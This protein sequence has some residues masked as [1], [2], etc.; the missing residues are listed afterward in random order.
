[1]RKIG[2]AVTTLLLIVVL[3]LMLLSADLLP[4][5]LGEEDQTKPALV[6]ARFSN[7]LEEETDHVLDVRPRLV[8]KTGLGHIVV[9]GGPVKHIEVKVHAE[10]KASTP[11]RAQELLDQISIETITTDN[12]N[13]FIVHTPRVQ[14]NETAKADLTILV[15]NDTKLDLNTAL[16]QVEVT[17]ST[18]DLRALSQ[19]GTI[20]VDNFQGNAYL[21][22]NLG[23]IEI[24]NAVFEKELAAISQLGDLRI[25]ASLAERNILE[26]SLGDLELLLSPEESYVLEGNLSLGKFQIRVPFKGQQSHDHIKGI[27][28]EGTQRGSI[29]VTLSLGSL[30]LR[31]N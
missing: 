9:Q 27:V 24:S 2:I 31:Q 1:M 21:E 8:A 3:A 25:Q 15:P 22:T 4:F 5:S 18:G 12:E 29:S 17:G 20:K 7:I 26:S 16:G 30:E 13:R 28:G 6:P 23:N 14:A 10:T 11:R 19:L